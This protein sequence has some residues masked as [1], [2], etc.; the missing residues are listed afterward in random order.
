MTASVATMQ[1]KIPTR[2]GVGRVWSSLCASWLVLAICATPTGPGHGDELN[3]RAPVSTAVPSTNVS[4]VLRL[5]NGDTLLGQLVEIAPTN[6]VRWRHSAAGQTLDVDY[7]A[8]SR[9]RLAWTNAVAGRA[10]GT[11]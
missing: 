10:Q 8:V 1:K 3:A 4:S 5:A 2:R 9:I 11:C 7:V 6:T